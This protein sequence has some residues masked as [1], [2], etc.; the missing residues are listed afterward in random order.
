MSA[1]NDHD[2]LLQVNSKLDALTEEFRRVSNGQGFP[3]CA[4]RLARL[5]SIEKENQT[6]HKRIDAANARFWW[7][8]TFSVGQLAAFV[9]S[10]IKGGISN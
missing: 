3:R 4:D 2:L 5:N 10:V 7:L 8:V 9:I 1:P 6:L